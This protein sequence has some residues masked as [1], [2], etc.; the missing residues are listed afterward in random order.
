MTLRR[1]GRRPIYTLQPPNPNRFDRTAADGGFEPPAGDVSTFL[2]RARLR[3]WKTGLIRAEC[4]R[5]TFPL[6]MPVLM[7]VIES[8][9]GTSLGLPVEGLAQDRITWPHEWSSRHQPL[10]FVRRDI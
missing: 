1:L 2:R 4:W 5:G 10:F 8:S 7:G 6:V 9:A 3:R